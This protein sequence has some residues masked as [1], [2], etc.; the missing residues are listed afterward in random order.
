VV[1][2]AGTTAGCK[3]Q[4]P[5]V[6]A[7]D[8]PPTKVVVADEALRPGDQI[9]VQVPRMDELSSSDPFTINADGSIVL[10]I[11]GVIDVEGMTITQITE[12][13][14]KRL[15]GII[16]NPDARVSVV[17]PRLPVVTVVGEVTT[18]GRFEVQHNEGV[19]PALALAGG[20]TEFADLDEIYVVRKYPKYERIR[21]RYTDLTGG[22]ERSLAFT[23]RDGDVIVVE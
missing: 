16:V 9:L 5:F 4:H 8:L 19:L 20:L 23:L 22:V 10:P 7:N 3:P 13:V 15:K 14:N 1:A 2:G 6:W 12:Q 21:F 11:I 18:P 17:N